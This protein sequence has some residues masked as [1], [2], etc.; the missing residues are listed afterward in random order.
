MEISEQLALLPEKP[1]V[2]LMRDQN[3]EILYIGKALSLKQRVRSYFQTGRST[4]L[5]TRVLASQ[6]VTIDTIITDSELEALILECN[7]IKKHA[8]KYNIRLKDDKHYP[9]IRI[10]MQEDFPRLMIARSIHK[11]GAKYYGPYISSYA[12]DE[13]L[14]LLRAIFP[15]RTCR[16]DIGREH[17]ERP[18]LNYHIK[19][20]LAPC[21]GLVSREV[22]RAMIHEI[23]L[24]LEG[25]QQDLVKDLRTKM[26]A[27][28]ASLEFE[29]A[30]RLRDRLQAVERVVEKQ[31]IISSALED[32]DVVAISQS[33]DDS[34]AQVFFIRGGKLLGREHFVLSGTGETERKE[35]LSAFLK[36]YYSN[37]P[38]V[39]RE[40][41][42]PEEI[43]ES[44]I[45]EQWLHSKRG[46]AVKIQVPKRGKKR[47]ML[48]LVEKNAVEV[49]EQ[50]AEK[51]R[52]DLEA[53]EGAVAAL[54]EALALPV[55]PSR[56]ECYDI[57]NIQGTEAV[58]SMVVFVGGKPAPAEYRHFRIKTIEGPNDYAMMREVLD[59]RFKRALAERERG[60]GKGKFAA[61]PDL[62][63]VDG[64][65]GQLGVA[66]EVLQALS[67]SSIPAIG[68]AKEF[69]TIFRTD[70]QE[71]LSLP[72]SPA[73]HLLQR[74]R[75][76]AHRF[77][78]TYHRN[79]RTKRMVES[80]LDRI[81]GI[82]AKRRVALLKKFG[83]VAAIK[84]ATVEEIA[85]TPGL[86]P[87]LAQRVR[88]Y[89]LTAE[90]EYPG[91]G[92]TKSRLTGKRVS[93]KIIKQVHRV[94]KDDDGDQ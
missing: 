34:C 76:E 13:T 45:I 61:L 74:L 43:D 16:K 92:R 72:D 58:G 1:G 35:V 25:R 73:R 93:D 57:S 9:Y 53:T 83:S 40:L 3:G 30:A 31:K 94:R 29:Q 20:C 60:E 33:G 17:P 12:V 11:D 26:Q 4:T 32:Q 87:G 84:A 90:P 44:R 42:L 66:V 51:R 67:L 82:G 80:V 91:P 22:Y 28:A 49:L 24:F 85:A 46:A 89:L 37:T 52:H 71:P 78:V 10:T 63:V 70:G 62:L 56:I 14:Q 54:Q 41:I 39:P 88:D 77:A 27:A 68:L 36:Q 2:Y 69:E 8:P 38:Y 7:L 19:R 47:E 23:C 15:L 59:R 6:I 65:K 64:G 81:E 50:L 75:D 21:Q 18:C 79:L 5:K 86:N 48:E 55:P